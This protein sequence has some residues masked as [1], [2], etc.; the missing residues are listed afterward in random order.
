MEKVAKGAFNFDG[1]EWQQ[2]SAEAK[3]FI[4]KMLE[5]D[6]AKRYNAEQANNDAW[7]K[8]YARKDIVE[9]PIIN[10]ALENMRTFRV[11]I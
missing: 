11:I 10:K 1:E 6:P 3:N 4:K 5:F 7:L 2:I 9:V 8:K